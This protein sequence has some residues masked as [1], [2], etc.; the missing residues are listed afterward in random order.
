M[1]YG[2][3][4]DLGFSSLVFSNTQYKIL[5]KCILS[6]KINPVIMMSYCGFLHAISFTSWAVIKI[7]VIRSANLQ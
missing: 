7:M 1:H 4:E 6:N 3:K 2:K 5:S